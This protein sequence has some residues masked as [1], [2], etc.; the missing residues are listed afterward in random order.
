MKVPAQEAFI[1]PR[2]NSRLTKKL[3]KVN[4]KA[5][6]VIPYR[7]LGGKQFIGYR[8]KLRKLS[9][10]MGSGI[11]RHNKQLFCILGS[12]WASGSGSCQ[13]STSSRELVLCSLAPG[14]AGG[15][16]LGTKM[17]KQKWKEVGKLPK[18][19]WHHWSARLGTERGLWDL[20]FSDFGFVC[21]TTARLSLLSRH[22]APLVSLGGMSIWTLFTD[23][24]G[25]C[26]CKKMCD[27]VE[28]LIK[29]FIDMSLAWLASIWAPGEL[30][31]AFS[32]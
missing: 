4:N 8:I 20:L 5:T 18:K 2:E 9:N 12:E 23:L 24:H 14:Y 10:Q 27:G 19:M 1:Q 6:T 30:E 21:S 13:S 22:R 28:G 7:L 3:L 29:T 26:W 25:H 31:S 16:I 32:N 15:G 17:E 11:Q